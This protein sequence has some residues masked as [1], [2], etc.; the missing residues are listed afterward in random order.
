MEPAP[1]RSALSGRC[2]TALREQAASAH[3]P[4]RRC[5]KAEVATVASMSPI[6]DHALS[7][8][9]G[10]EILGD[11]TDAVWKDH[12]SAK[13]NAIRTWTMLE[14]ADV[15]VARF[16]EEY[17]QRNTAFDLG[18]AAARGKPTVV[19]HPPGLRHALKEIDAAPM[20]VAETP[21]QVAR[22]LRHIVTK[23]EKVDS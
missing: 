14:R 2:R 17:R 11:E 22:I 13:I 18:Y 21:E 1:A 12:K 10:T 16:G 23:Q 5:V 6:T 9:I 15:V 8:G 7:D 19:L 20:A 3:D 4:A